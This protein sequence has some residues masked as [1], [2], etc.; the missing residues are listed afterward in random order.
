MPTAPYIQ[1]AT[2]CEFLVTSGRPP[3]PIM[4]TEDVTRKGVDGR[5]FRQT[6]TRADQGTVTVTWTTNTWSGAQSDID[7]LEGM[8]GTICNFAD[9]QGQVFGNLLLKNV[10]GAEIQPAESM[11]GASGNYVVKATLTLIDQS[12]S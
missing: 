9:D 4:R 2:T 7:T 5:E 10:T 3:G 1:N 8:G 11:A 6:G 12:A